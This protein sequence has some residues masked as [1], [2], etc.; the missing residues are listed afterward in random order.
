MA[1][2]LKYVLSNACKLP[3]G[4]KSEDEK[5]GIAYKS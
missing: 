5:F 3:N 2:Y 4:R 1:Y